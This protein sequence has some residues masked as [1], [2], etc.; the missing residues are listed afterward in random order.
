MVRDGLL[1]DVAESGFDALVARLRLSRARSHDD[2]IRIL[3][4]RSGLPP[5][6]AHRMMNQQDAIDELV[7]DALGRIA[8][9]ASPDT[10][11]ATQPEPSVATTDDEWFGQS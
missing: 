6:V 2:A 10:G 7:A 3:V 4:D 8:Q 11:P 5:S 1:R 9:D